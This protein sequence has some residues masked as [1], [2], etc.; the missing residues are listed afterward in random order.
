MKLFT[1]EP[2][3]AKRSIPKYL[4][5]FPTKF[6]C[7][8]F[9]Q[10]D[11]YFLFSL[12]ENFK[13]TI[14]TRLLNCLKVVRVFLLPAFVWKMFTNLRIL[15]SVFQFQ[16]NLRGLKIR[17]CTYTGM[18]FSSVEEMLIFGFLFLTLKRLQISSWNLVNG[19]D[20]RVHLL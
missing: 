4:E 17:I 7:C 8:Q 9:H 15:S 2:S 12:F 5:N 3:F 19:L 1:H 20:R 11:T 14:N 10:K 6:R 13:N 18:S 16:N